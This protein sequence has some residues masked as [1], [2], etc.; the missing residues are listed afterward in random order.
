MSRP[1]SQKKLEAPILTVI[2]IVG[3]AL[4]ALLFA[5]MY[6][7]YFQQAHPEGSV[8][9]TGTI[10]GFEGGRCTPLADSQYYIMVDGKKIAARPGMGD[11]NIP[12]GTLGIPHED[13]CLKALIG[14]RV[15]V[16]GKPVSNGFTLAGSN[17]YYLKLIE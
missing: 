1:L 15:E 10:T 17:S 11:G 5:P 6:S 12:F 2:A 9:F 8:R 13:Q 7:Y 16:Y 14:K 3:L 4:L